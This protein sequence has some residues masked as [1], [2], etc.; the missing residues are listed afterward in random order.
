MGPSEIVIGEL[1]DP[2]AA[3]MTSPV[4]ARVRLRELTLMLDGAVR[5]CDEAVAPGIASVIPPRLTFLST[6]GTAMR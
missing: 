4:V 2:T 5:E 3:P 6:F 1:T